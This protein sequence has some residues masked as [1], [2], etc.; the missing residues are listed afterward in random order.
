MSEQAKC[1][2]LRDREW[3]VKAYATTAGGVVF[4]AEGPADWTPRTYRL[5]YGSYYMDSPRL[6][7]DAVS[8]RQLRDVLT[9]FITRVTN[10]EDLDREQRGHWQLRDQRWRFT[11]CEWDDYL[12]FVALDTV[13]PFKHEERTDKAP[14]SLA[15]PAL[16][17]NVDSARRLCELLDHVLARTNA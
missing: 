1:W 11:V 16:R 3:T 7:A 17:I 6:T 15:S 14:M 12:T 9:R 2:Q 4:H 13:S 5:R 10:G 8:A